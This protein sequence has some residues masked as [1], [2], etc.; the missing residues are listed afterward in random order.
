MRSTDVLCYL[1]VATLAVLSTLGR[2]GECPRWIYFFVY[3]YLAERRDGEGERKKRV[4]RR[5]CRARLAVCLAGKLKPERPRNW[6]VRA[7]LPRSPQL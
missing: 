3:T 4:R 2:A 6:F 7:E 1:I 5:E